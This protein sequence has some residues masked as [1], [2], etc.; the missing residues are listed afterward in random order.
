MRKVLF[1]IVHS[2]ESAGRASMGD[3][4]HVLGFLIV[5]QNVYGSRTCD[6][7][8]EFILGVLLMR[9]ARLRMSVKRGRPSASDME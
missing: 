1:A 5:L 7:W 6:L 8:C 3:L 2:V 4:H 9:A